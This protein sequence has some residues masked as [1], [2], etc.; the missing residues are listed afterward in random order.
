MQDLFSREESVLSCAKAFLKT[1]SSDD[2]IYKEQFATITLE[3]ERVLK[4][5]RRITRLSDRTASE[6]NS[7][8]LHLLDKVHF[9]GLT[10]IYN[11]RYLEETFGKRVKDL[12]HSNGNISVLM[13]DVD[14]FKKYNDTYGHTVG[15]K[16]L[17]TVAETLA[18]SICRSEDFVARYGGEEFIAILPNTPHDGAN[19]IAKQMIENIRQLNICHKGNDVAPHITISIGF[20]SATLKDHHTGES[21]IKKA[22][23]A[24]YLSK[25]RGR[26]CYTF[27]DFEEGEQ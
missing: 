14:F 25:A 2:T 21:L 24:L 1:I 19:A 12:A 20:T 9:D 5:L 22:D 7:N 11:R 17:K 13:I 26:N 23:E 15:D 8:K 10:G 6:L 4:Q 3:Y 16:C 18:N 27:L